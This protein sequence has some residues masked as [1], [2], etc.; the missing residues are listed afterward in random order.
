MRANVCLECVAG[1]IVGV[2]ADALIAKGTIIAYG[3]LSETKISGISPLQ[4][5]GKDLKLEGFL[6]HYWL[7]EKS[8][9]ALMGVMKQSKT[10]LDEVQVHKEFGFH[11]V[12]EAVEEYKQNMSKGKIML[13][14]SLT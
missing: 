14:P 4:L 8:T 6:L 10:L 12:K 7:K 5:I 1:P 13:K 3:N 11:Q 9:W 2:I